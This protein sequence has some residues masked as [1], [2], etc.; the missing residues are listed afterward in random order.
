MTSHDVVQAVRRRL[1]VRKVGHLG[2]LDPMATGVLPLALGKA[3]R[4]VEFLKGGNK[5]Y[6]GTIRLGFSTDTYDREGVPASE[7]VVPGVTQERL[8]QLAVEMSGERQQTPPP[9]SAKKI[10][11]VRAYQLARQGKTVPLAAQPV[12]IDALN[13]ALSTSTT[14]E[15]ELRIRCSAGTYVRSVAHD[16]G[17]RL[18]CG[19]HLVR[20][21]RTESGEFSLQQSL[22]LSDFIE[23]SP[24]DLSARL[25]PLS[26]VL[27]EY[28]AL[29]VDADTQKAIALGRVFWWTVSDGGKSGASLLYR[30]LS[31]EGQLIALAKPLSSSDLNDPSKPGFSSFHPSV[32]LITATDRASD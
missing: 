21:R 6:E 22:A 13:F 12:H 2:T 4:L 31:A 32:V 5:V 27:T 30:V 10:Q 7:T 1:K 19:A 9:F 3:T 25:I 18:G 28:P 17:R 16:L 20:L 29:Q 15:V 14:D 23:A 11:G 24:A 26:R 8:T